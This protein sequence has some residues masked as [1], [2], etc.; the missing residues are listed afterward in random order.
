VL[1]LSTIIAGNLLCLTAVT[2]L[3]FAGMR[4]LAGVG[5]GFSTAAFGML[6]ATRFPDRNFAIFSG[7][8]VIAIAAFGAVVPV[9]TTYGGGRAL[10]GL[11]AVPAV[12]ALCAIKL[13]PARIPESGGISS[14]TSQS[15]ARSIVFGL[16]MMIFFFTAVSGFFAYLSVIGAESGTKASSTAL[17]ISGLFLFGGS[18]GSFAAASAAPRLNRLTVIVVALLTESGAVS[19]TATF[20]GPTHFLIGTAIFLFFWFLSY[21]FLMGVLAEIDRSGQLTVWGILAQSL[22]WVIGP[23]IG[24]VL[25][26]RHAF[27]GLGSL[28]AVCFLLSMISA[29]ASRRRSWSFPTHSVTGTRR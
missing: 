28:S 17:I 9:I 10:F 27:S 19:F 14:T 5:C 23:A 1:A 7:G 11:I 26:E 16:L 21:P 2:Y 6:A 29:I 13:I 18:V 4:F 24:G 3:H 15:T 22:G 20:P 8:T 25:I 12:C